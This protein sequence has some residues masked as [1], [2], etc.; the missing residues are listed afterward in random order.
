MIRTEGFSIIMT[1]GDTGAV[2]FHADDFD[3]LDGDL[4]VFTVKQY[5]QVMM[6]RIIEPD[7][8][9]FTVFFLNPD[10]EN[11]RGGEYRYDLRIVRGAVFDE[12]GRIV[13][14][15]SVMTPMPPS[16]LRIERAVGAV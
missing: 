4:A 3:V 8:N 13:D 14:G 11:W 5:G 10:T 16:L 1:A 9:G 15:M 6:E 2:T 7:W 12:D